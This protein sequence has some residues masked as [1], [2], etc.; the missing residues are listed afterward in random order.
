M[1]SIEDYAQQWLDFVADKSVVCEGRMISFFVGTGMHPGFG[2]NCGRCED[3]PLHE[4]LSQ[5]RPS[6]CSEFRIY[7]PESTQK[8]ENGHLRRNFDEWNRSQQL[9]IVKFEGMEPVESRG[10]DP[11]YA[12]AAAFMDLHRAGCQLDKMLLFDKRYQVREA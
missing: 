10:H 11:A 12:A 1:K 4:R 8:P 7:H 2:P 3:C 6:R 9:W 5:F